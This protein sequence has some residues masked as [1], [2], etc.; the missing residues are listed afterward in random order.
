M[1]VRGW[2]Q[3]HCHNTVVALFSKVQWLRSQWSCLLQRHQ[4]LSRRGRRGMEQQ[5]QEF[6]LCGFLNR[7]WFFRP[8]TFYEKGQVVGCQKCQNSTELNFYGYKKAFQTAFRTLRNIEGFKG[9]AFLVSH[10]PEHFENGAWN[11]GGSCNR[12]KP[13][14]LEEKGVYESGDIVKALHE[15]QVEEFNAAREKGLR[16]GLIDVTDAMVVRADA[17]PSRFKPGNKKVNDCV[18]WCLPGAVDTWNEFLLYLMKLDG[19]KHNTMLWSCQCF[20]LL[21]V[22]FNDHQM[23]QEQ[24]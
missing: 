16:F 13:F 20:A 15:I 12:T 8:L 23:V 14:S 4:A 6:W 5:N 3:F 7:K 11:E 21:G 22:I 1:V 17:H 24:G 10:S 18:H 9:V 2:L 19:E